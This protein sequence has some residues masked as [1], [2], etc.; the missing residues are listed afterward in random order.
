MLISKY[1]NKKSYIHDILPKD[2]KR[3]HNNNN[4]FNGGLLDFT[5]QNSN[6]I[7][8]SNASNYSK[9]PKNKIYNE[10]NQYS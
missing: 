10:I 4:S 2:M 6:K 3:K 8:N 1:L 9:L 5:K 7:N